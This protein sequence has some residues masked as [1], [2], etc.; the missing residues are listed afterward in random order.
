MLKNITLDDKAKTFIKECLLQGNEYAHALLNSPWSGKITTFLP[1]EIDY[2][3]IDF[4]QSIFLS[5]GIKIYNDTR[6]IIFNKTY[7]FFQKE[8]N[9]YALF[10]TYYNDDHLKNMKPLQDLVYHEN[11]IYFLL[12]ANS[13]SQNT[14]DAFASARNYPF[15]C[16][17]IDLKSKKLPL[18]NKQKITNEQLDILVQETVCVFVGAFDSEGF[19]LWE[20]KLA[21]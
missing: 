16:G 21:V 11:E 20:R 7:L 3:H 13:Y 9:R 1:E 17:L 12:D 8:I 5:T 10:E 14:K 2:S 18:Y 15:I 19:L 6:N 4:S